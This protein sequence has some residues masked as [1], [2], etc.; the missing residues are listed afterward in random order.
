MSDNK[1]TVRDR[2]VAHYLVATAEQL[3]FTYSIE[4]DML[5]VAYPLALDV[6][7]WPR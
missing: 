1:L 3:G 5:A 7:S 4:N 2:A 6:I